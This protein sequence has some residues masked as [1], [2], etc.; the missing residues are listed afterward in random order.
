MTKH[1]VDNQKLFQEMVLFTDKCKIASNQGLP[2]PKVPEYIGL[3]IY[4]IA[5]RLASKS[6]FANYT[7]RD[8]MVADGIETCIR[9]V[10]RFDP[11]KSEKPFAYFTQ[12]I[13]YA[14]LQRIQK[15]KK[16]SYIKHK[17][18]ENSM[19]MNTLVDIGIEDS[20]QFD[21]NSVEIDSARISDLIDKFEKTKAKKNNIQVSDDIVYSEEEGE[22][23]DDGVLYD[24]N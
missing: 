2:R 10:D 8:D 7:Y 6:N 22:D 4:T 14:F 18:L 1:Y 23:D 24:N 20:Q 12:I 16:H 5:N 21:N 3:A 19:L 15:E 17:M 9:Y 11:A 13:Y